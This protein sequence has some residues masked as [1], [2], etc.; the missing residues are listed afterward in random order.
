[1]IAQ[2][3]LRSFLVMLLNLNSKHLVDNGKVVREILDPPLG[4]KRKL[5]MVDGNRINLLYLEILFVN[6]HVV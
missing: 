5:I 1:M 6:T 3:T 4:S 2:P